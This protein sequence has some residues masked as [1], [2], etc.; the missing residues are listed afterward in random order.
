M[1]ID[2]K[3]MGVIWKVESCMEL[4][5]FYNAREVQAGTGI[6]DTTAAWVHL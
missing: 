6:L 2:L 1:G 3:K 5:L 4:H